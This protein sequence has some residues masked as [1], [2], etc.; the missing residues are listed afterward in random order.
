MDSSP[1]TRL[2]NT[3]TQ[4]IPER[5]WRMPAVF[6]S[7]GPGSRRCVRHGPPEPERTDPQRASV[8]HAPAAVLAYRREHGARVWTQHRPPGPTGGAATLEDMR[9][10]QRGLFAVTERAPR[11]TRARAGDT[12]Q[13]RQALQSYSDDLGTLTPSGMELDHDNRSP[14]TPCLSAVEICRAHSRRTSCVP[15]ML[16]DEPRARLY[17]IAWYLDDR[18][19]QVEIDLAN[20]L[21]E[22]SCRLEG[23]PS[24]VVGDIDLRPGR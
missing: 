10:P 1:M 3:M 22:R 2:L 16:R 4:L 20:P 14:Q 24:I 17:R 18:V 5:A 19:A 7:M 8:R 11:A 15:N 12:D 13:A 9:I 23:H 21:P 6:R